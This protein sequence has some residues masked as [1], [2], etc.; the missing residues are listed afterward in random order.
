[1]KEKAATSFDIHVIKHVRQVKLLQ[2]RAVNTMV[3]AMEF[4]NNL[5]S[6]TY[7]KT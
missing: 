3:F 7:S 5:H 1:M 2:A 6:K 4:W